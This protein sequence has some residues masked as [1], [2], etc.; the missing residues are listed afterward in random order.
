MEIE[1]IDVNIY[2]SIAG[3]LQGE[4]RNSEKEV[5]EKKESS[6]IIEKAKDKGRQ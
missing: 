2:K 4:S 6:L 3:E 5:S 1:E